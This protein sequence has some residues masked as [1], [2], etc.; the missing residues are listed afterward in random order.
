MIL[1]F[2]LVPFSFTMVVD[3]VTFLLVHLINIH[4]SYYFYPTQLNWQEKRTHLPVKKLE[5]HHGFGRIPVS[6]FG[7]LTVSRFVFD[8]KHWSAP[9]SPVLVL[10]YCYTLCGPELTGCWEWKG[11][12]VRFHFCWLPS[13]CSW[14]GVQ[15]LCQA[16]KSEISQ[17]PASHSVGICI[18]YWFTLAWRC[19]PEAHVD[20]RSEQGPT[21]HSVR[22]CI[23]YWFALA[24]RCVP[25]AHANVCSECLLLCNA[26]LLILFVSKAVWEYSKHCEHIKYSENVNLVFVFMRLFSSRNL[27]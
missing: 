9:C 3:N 21:S 8:K 2:F 26:R 11:H 5:K 17:S 13:L 6:V 14:A 10:Q 20:V 22:I 16:A 4:L 7:P 18:H 25:E 19:V 1:Y 23:Y 12:R 27:Y 24:W 15:S